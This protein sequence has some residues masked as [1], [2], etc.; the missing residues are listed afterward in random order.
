MRGE[1]LAAF[2]GMPKPAQ[3]AIAPHRCC[4]CDTLAADL[5][6]HTWCALPDDVLRGHVWDL[7]LLSDEAKQYYLPAWLLHA[8]ADDR[9]DA[10]DALVFALDADHRWKPVTPY[11]PQQWLVIDRW[12]AHMRGRVD[13]F[14]QAD[15]DRVRARLPW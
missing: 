2:A 7:P 6:P 8:L 4:E 3:E 11:T 12:L 14:F 13:E 10:T 1:I 15:I 5:F 9:S